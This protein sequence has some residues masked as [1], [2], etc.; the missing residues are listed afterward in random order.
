MGCIV[1][2]TSPGIWQA[3]P[4]ALGANRAAGSP[5]YPLPSGRRGNR[6]LTIPHQSLAGG[7]ARSGIPGELWCG[8]PGLP[9]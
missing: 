4:A 5:R 6:L 3:G 2:L 7:E 8:T 9:V 1:I